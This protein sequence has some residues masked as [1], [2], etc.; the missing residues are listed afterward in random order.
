MKRI[1]HLGRSETPAIR[2]VVEYFPLSWAYK[3]II[4]RVHQRSH[5]RRSTG[6]ELKWLRLSERTRD[7]ERERETGRD[8]TERQRKRK[9]F[10]GGEL[11][12]FQ[13]GGVCVLQVLRH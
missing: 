10:S 5:A 6:S 8:G 12:P 4:S 11:I 2:K 1:R 9:R 3:F 13:S 7:G